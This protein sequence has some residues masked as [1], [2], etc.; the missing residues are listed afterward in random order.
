MVALGSLFDQKNMYKMSSI[1]ILVLISLC[2]LSKSVE[3]QLED[4]LL[5]NIVN[6]PSKIIAGKSINLKINVKN[7]NK[8]SEVRLK[9][10]YMVLFQINRME[11]N[12]QN[13]RHKIINYTIAPNDTIVFNKKF[14]IDHSI[15]DGT[16]QLTV[17][18]E[19]TINENE[20]VYGS[21]SYS[22]KVIGGGYSKLLFIFL[23][24]IVVVIAL[25]FKKI[26]SKKLDNIKYN[27]NKCYQC[28]KK[29]KKDIGIYCDFNIDK[30][31]KCLNGP[32]CSD[33]CLINHKSIHTSNNIEYKEL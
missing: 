24:I 30:H 27:K 23:I 9:S 5:V 12:I 22:V 15:P 14:D 6:P 33:K 28:N 25:Y 2:N 21:K 31:T 19:G 18:I 29:M 26:R 7:F 10:V 11:F 8:T 1:I 3:G 16:Y 4:E 17:S 20:S 32:F 13:Q